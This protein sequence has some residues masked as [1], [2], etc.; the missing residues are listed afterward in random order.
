VSAVIIGELE[1]QCG[2]IQTLVN[3]SDCPCD[4]DLRRRLQQ[5]RVY[6]DGYFCRNDDGEFVPMK[7]SPLPSCFN[8]YLRASF[9]APVVIGGIL[10]ITVV[11]TVGLLI[12]YRKSRRVQQVRECLAMYP[13][14]FV[15]TALQYLMIQNR[16]E[17]PAL[18]RYD[19]FVFVQDDDQSSIHTH[20]L[21]ALQGERSVI[22]RDNI[23]LGTVELDKTLEYISDCR[24]IV[25]VLT[26][27]FLS[28][29]VCMD[30]M[31]RVQFSRP[32]ALIPVVWE[33]SLPAT[34]ASIEHLLQTG[35]PLYWPGELK[36]NFWSSL[37]ERTIPLQ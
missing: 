20:F 10:G 32:H 4:D 27:N 15:R 18:F 29:G 8:P 31:R 34:D 28:D 17:D 9:I 22:T 5:I 7:N 13:V 30:F 33:Q 3:G 25:P 21:A 1:Q 37:L 26:S 11:A 24:W 14:R 2:V 19:M 23:G 12:Y 35:E 6:L 16:A 36:D